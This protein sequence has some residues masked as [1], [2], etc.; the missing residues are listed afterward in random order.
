MAN[1]PTSKCANLACHNRTRFCKYQH[2]DMP[3]EAI[4]VKQVQ[5]AEHFDHLLQLILLC[6]FDLMASCTSDHNRYNNNDDA[7]GDEHSGA[8]RRCWQ[9][10]ITI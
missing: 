8:T 10:G 9:Y 3:T 6:G 7:I 5:S 4:M 2:V 1:L